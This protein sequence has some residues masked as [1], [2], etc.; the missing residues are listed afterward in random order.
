MTKKTYVIDMPAFLYN[1]GGIVAMHKLC[2]DL[3]LL[4]EKA[5][6]TCPTT[7]KDLNAPYVGTAKFSKDAVVV[8]YPEITAG[9]PLKAKHVVRWALNTPGKCAGRNEGDFYTY[10]QPSDLIFKYSE[11]FTLRDE[12]ESKGLLTTTFIDRN[13]FSN[14]R[15]PRKGSAFF[16]KKGGMKNK[17]HPDDSIDLSKLEHDWKAMSNVLKSVEYFYCYDNACF[18][19]VIAAICGCVSVV[20]PDSDMSA[21]E[22]YSKFPHKRCGVAYGLDM[23]QHAKDTLDFAEKCF[24]E[25]TEKQL[26]TVR[27]FV[28]ICEAL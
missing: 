8:I 9:N 19:V 1:S 17:I 21:E 3:N 16:V 14:P 10:K 15:T 26:D 27:N 5:Y 13:Y 20:V 11:Y 24:A 25:F 28:N 12:S 23:L 4:G 7:H 6:I 18:W 2:H 22:W